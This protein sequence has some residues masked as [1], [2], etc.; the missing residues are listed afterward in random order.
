M[1]WEIDPRMIALFGSATRVRTLAVLSGEAE[2]LT[3]YRIARASQLAPTKV[4]GELR[5]LQNAGIVGERLTATG[6]RGWE[7]VDTGIRDFVRS[8]VRVSFADTWFRDATARV[9]EARDRLRSISAPDVTQFK[10]RP[11]EVP[12][13]AEF[14]RPRSKDATLKRLGLPGSRR[15]RPRE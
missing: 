6:Q 12:N 2:P 11:S 9:R 3:G 15:R 14:E 8:R 1:A 13:R 4:Y 7:V 10:A 5:R